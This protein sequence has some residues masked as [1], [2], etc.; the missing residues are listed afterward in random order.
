MAALTAAE[1]VRD[2]VHAI[3]QGLQR[4]TSLGCVI[5][6]REQLYY[7]RPDIDAINAEVQ[8][9]QRAGRWCRFHAASW[10]GDG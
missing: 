9:K 10:G 7:S 1:A 3:R 6:N 4:L 2:S 5:T 8:C